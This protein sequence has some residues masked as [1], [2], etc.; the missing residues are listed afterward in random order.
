MKLSK[1]L[2]LKLIEVISFLNG[3]KVI[4]A[5]SGGVDSSLLAFLSKKYAKDTL[6][7]TER[8]ILYPEEEI[9][10]ASQFATKYGINHMIIE[11][12]PLQDEDFQCNPSN[13]C[14]ICN[15]MLL[16]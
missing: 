2:N 3:K 12:D 15:G 7:I 16:I 6:L 4:V 5:F 1:N 9:K 11:R 14:Y 13:R 10:E 8:S